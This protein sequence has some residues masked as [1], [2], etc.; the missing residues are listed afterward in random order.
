MHLVLYFH[1]VDGI[2]NTGTCYT[3]YYPYIKYFK[4]NKAN[5]KYVHA[6]SSKI[7]DKM[8]PQA[9][10]RKY[11]SV[12]VFPIY[13]TKKF[14]KKLDHFLSQIKIP[15]YLYLDDLQ[16]RSKHVK[17]GKLYKKFHKVICTYPY[18]INKFYNFVTP[19]QIIPLYHVPV[20]PYIPD[21]RI[22]QKKRFLLTGSRRPEYK[23]RNHL[24]TLVNKYP[25]D[26]HTKY[27]PQNVY[28]K[29][30]NSYKF[31]FA[32]PSI[33]KYIVCKHFEIPYAGSILVCYDSIKDQ[34]NKIGFYHMKNCIMFNY[35]NLDDIIKFGLDSENSEEL[36]TIRLNGISLINENHTIKNRIEILENIL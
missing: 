10:N 12:I 34:L 19:D 8:S 31:C 5:F 26:S 24:S 30:I 18:L 11:S 1:K 3:V 36:E 2:N 23:I 25:I 33:F 28:Y 9:I 35:S 6:Y 20:F 16:V 21:L 27:I 7:L 22:Q 14:P 13:H 17:L 4:D 29:L 15:K 32:T